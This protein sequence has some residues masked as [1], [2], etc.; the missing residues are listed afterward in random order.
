MLYCSSWEK[1]TTIVNL[2]VLTQMDP[3]WICVASKLA[4]IAYNFDKIFSRINSEFSLSEDIRVVAMQE[5]P[6]VY[7]YFEI[8]ALSNNTI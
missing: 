7:L 3:S 2:N 4:N 6:S 1:N 8:W 5:N